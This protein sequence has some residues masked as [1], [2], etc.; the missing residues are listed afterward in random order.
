MGLLSSVGGKNGFR[1]TRCQL[2]FTRLTA[3]EDLI[4]FSRRESF[5][6]YISS[7]GI[8]SV[9]SFA[10]GSVTVMEPSVLHS[11]CRGTILTPGQST[12]CCCRSCQVD[13]YKVKLRVH[14]SDHG[15]KLNGAFKNP[16]LTIFRNGT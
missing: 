10:N 2:H 6:S 5:K 4:A 15:R 16:K 1:D 11:L 7:T 9:S 14:Y 13:S 12:F 3:R 8:S